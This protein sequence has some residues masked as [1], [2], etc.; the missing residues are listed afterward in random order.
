M[1]D[2]LKDQN[3]MEIKKLADEGD[4]EKMYEYGRKR[5]I[6]DEDCQCDIQEA[7]K[8]ISMAAEKGHEKAKYLLQIIQNDSSINDDKTK[9][10]LEEEEQA[11]S[12]TEQKPQTN[13]ITHLKDDQFFTR[14]REDVQIILNKVKEN[15]NKI[16][17]KKKDFSDAHLGKKSFIKLVP[18][19]D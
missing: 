13:N 8:Y 19:K 11:T 10:Q 18:L 1:F 15:Y 16:A 14:E 17:Q 9:P 5:F 3:L 2:D 7:K 12:S 4:V 6:G